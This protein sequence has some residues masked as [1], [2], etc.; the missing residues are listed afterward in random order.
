MIGACSTHFARQLPDIDPT[1]TK[2]WIDSLDAVVSAPRARRGPG[3]S[4]PSCWSGP[5]SSRSGSRPPPRRPTSTR[6]R[7]RQQPFFPGNEDIERR[8]RAFIRWNAAA[9]VI[10]ANKSADGI[11]GH[12][13]TY[14]SSASLYEVGFNHFFKG[15]DDGLAGDHVYYQGHAAPG[16]YA[17]A[18]LEGRL[19]E[20]NLD[21]FRMEIGGSGLSS[22]PAPPPDAALL[23]VPDG[24]D[25]A[26]PDQLDLPR[27]LQQVPP[28]AP[29]S[30]TRQPEPD[31][32]VPRRRRVRR[33][34]DPRRDLARRALR[35]RQPQLG[36]Q[37]QPPAPRRP[38]PRQRQDHP[39]T[40]G[41][42][43]G[44]GLERHQGRLGFAVGRAAP[45]R[46]RRRAP[47][48]DEP[49]PSTASTSATPPRTAPTSANTSSAPTRACASSS[50]TSPTEEIELLPRGGHDYQ[51]VY[52][53]FKKPHRRSPTSRPS[54]SPRR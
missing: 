50:S 16:I 29:S 12:L 15:K 2:E 45:P 42:V 49:P 44:G 4:S 27:P 20:T 24:V 11:G 41:R 51:K 18:F 5:T 34:R 10:R 1:E 38:G 53:A 19:T 46:R 40:R 7:P 21:N 22:Y 3:T 23:G 32:V 9:M 52:A 43:P 28:P 48:Q 30:R 37:L 17:R 54:S 39:G 8:I 36:H 47:Q 35:P 26:R 25:G 31:L 13:S 14:A 33:T 6:S